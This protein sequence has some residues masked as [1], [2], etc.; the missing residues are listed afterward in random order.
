MSNLFLVKEKE[1][2]HLVGFSLFNGEHTSDF[3]SALGPNFVL[4]I[5]E[6]DAT[7]FNYCA[8]SVGGIELPAEFL[9]GKEGFPWPLD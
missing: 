2:G 5:R 4:E 6:E 1:L 9:F 3:I 8:F 7:D